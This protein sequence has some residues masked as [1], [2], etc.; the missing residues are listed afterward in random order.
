MQWG[1]HADSAEVPYTSGA[2]YVYQ[3]WVTGFWG[4]TYYGGAEYTAP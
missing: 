2:Y 1:G 4:D 3:G